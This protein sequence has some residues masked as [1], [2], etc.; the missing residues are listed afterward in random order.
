MAKAGNN[1]AVFKEIIESK[2]G[3]ILNGKRIWRNNEKEVEISVDQTIQTDDFD[4]LIEI[5]SGN[6]AKL[7]V[8]QYTLLNEL[9]S[10]SGRKTVFVIVHFYNRNTNKPYNPERTLRNL[11]FINEK[12]FSGN[13][14]SFL[15]F[16]LQTFNEF[17]T[18]IKT[19]KE[20]NEKIKE[21][22]PNTVYSK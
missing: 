4:L 18:P 14:I 6:Y 11:N 20:L 1:E 22:L 12:T 3:K 10:S 15:A 19:L 13:G 16:N 7:I 17:L 5:D 8:G 9:H 2:F 21:T